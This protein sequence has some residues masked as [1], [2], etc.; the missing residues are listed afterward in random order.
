MQ[1]EQLN[2]EISAELRKCSLKFYSIECHLNY[3]VDLISS[4]LTEFDE[5]DEE[6]EHCVNDFIKLCNEFNAMQDKHKEVIKK[7]NKNLE[8]AQS[9]ENK[10]GEKLPELNFYLQ[11][12][13]R[14]MTI[15]QIQTSLEQIENKV[16]ELEPVI[17]K[18]NSPQLKAEEVKQLIRDVNEQK[19]CIAEL[20]VISTLMED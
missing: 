1:P 11:S 16:K 3:Y 12:E 14:S 10:Y 4:M 9:L 18:L 15:G 13:Y 19:R 2:N 6:T 5:I 20:M 8:L 17:S 7:H